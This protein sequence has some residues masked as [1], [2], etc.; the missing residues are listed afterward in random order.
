MRTVAVAAIATL[1]TVFGLRPA[2]AQQP[3]SPP[4]LPSAWPNI[5]V[6]AT[7]YIWLPWTGI[8]IRPSNTRIPSASETVDPGT[9]LDHLTWL[10]FMGAAEFR[11]G[12]Y[13]L[14]LDYMHTPVKS[15][16]NT[17]NILFSGGTG[18]TT[19]DT[20]TA[21]FLYRPISLPDQYV[22]VGAGVRGHG[23]A[24]SI[25]LNGGLLP[26]ANVS[27]SL[28][29]ADPLIA[30]RYHHDLGNGFS[31]TAYGDIGGFGLGAHIDWQLVGT[32]DYALN[33]W[34]DLHGGF[35]SL[36]FNYGGSRAE[37]DSHIYGP[38]LS[39]TFRF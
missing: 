39:A 37:F 16:F 17:A 25:V 12:A 23:L 33:S 3:D 24:G 22:D 38:I 6:L 11:V 8:S 5:E 19:I 15:G 30:A 29:W 31:A 21:M 20:G 4:A 7:P 36:N 18:A 34:I 9:L 27:N 32:I 14:I 2:I 26:P 28:S 35:R 1:L 10:P 13:G